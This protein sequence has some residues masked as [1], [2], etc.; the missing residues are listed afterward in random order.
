MRSRM[1]GR[2]DRRHGM[3]LGKSGNAVILSNNG[4][5][6]YLMEPY[7]TESIGM[8]VSGGGVGAR[9]VE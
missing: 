2:S 5:T 8:R 4:Y 1:I 9:E 6:A 3:H 7:G